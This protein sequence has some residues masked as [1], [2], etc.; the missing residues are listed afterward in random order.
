MIKNKE[1]YSYERD[2]VTQSLLGTWLTC[3]QKAAWQ[4]QGWTAPHTSAGLTYGTIMHGVLEHVYGMIQKKLLLKPPSELL[5]RKL[6]LKVEEQWR[7]ENPRTT[8]YSLEN[9]EISLLIA[10][11]TLPVYFDYWRKEDFKDI[12]WKALEQ[13]FKIPYTTHDGRKTFI[14]GK[15]DGVF[16]N[17]SIKLFET[18]TKSMF[19][20]D[21]LVDTL[22][23]ELQ[24]NLYTWAMRKVYNKTPSGILYNIIRRSGLR[25]GKD[26]TM[27]SFAVRISKDIQKRPE[28]YFVRMEIKVDVNQMLKFENE[29]EAMVFDFMDWWDAK[30]QKTYK[31]THA[32]ID[33]YGR[34]QFLDL[35]SDGNFSRY[36]KRKTVFNE[37][38]S[39]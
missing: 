12:K 6:L 26:E 8:K 15:K 34:C 30:E 23:F 11:S 9:L 1:F 27:A 36:A 7:A 29:L 17:P 28:W 20:E 25:R 10:E 33:K 19:N 14:R 16:G 31:N 3:R 39:F 21:D 32:C 22:W 13:Q 24:V 5:I 4:L 38:E 18:K 35:C 37:L 2:G